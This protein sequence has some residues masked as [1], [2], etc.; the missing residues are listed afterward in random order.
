VHIA[1][2]SPRP[3]TK[4]DTM[5]A[6]PALAVPYW[7]KQLRR[8]EL[9]G[10]QATIQTEDNQRWLGETVEVLVE[11]KVKGKWRGRSPQNKLVYF[12]DDADWTGNLAQVAVDHTGPWS[13]SGQLIG[14]PAEAIAV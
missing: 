12:A 1:A 2:F 11:D 10:T 5:E 8:V 13:L 9:E 6:D 3:G 4:A 14:A 7:K